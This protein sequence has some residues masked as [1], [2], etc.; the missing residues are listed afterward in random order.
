MFYQGEE[1]SNVVLRP[2][3]DDALEGDPPTD[4]EREDLPTMPV[5][6]EIAIGD[7]QEV[8]DDD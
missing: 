3:D 8:I 4:D 1:E 5:A 7:S 2:T 6:R